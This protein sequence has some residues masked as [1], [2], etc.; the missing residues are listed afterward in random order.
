VGQMSVVVGV[1]GGVGVRVEQR[2]SHQ[3]IRVPW[4]EAV[5]SRANLAGLVELLG[6]CRYVP[7]EE[8]RMWAEVV[9]TEAVDRLL[10]EL[11]DVC[12]AIRYAHPQMVQ[13]RLDLPEPTL[14]E[15]Q[16][17]LPWWADA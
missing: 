12:A 3:V 5:R 11:V 2:N 16:M 8:G 7:D 14:E 10:V 1:I 17:R 13:L 9:H 15:E 6:G 4:P